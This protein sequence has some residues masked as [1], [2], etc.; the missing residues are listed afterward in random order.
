MMSSSIYIATTKR[1][2]AS[3]RSKT[4]GH[5][6]VPQHEST[7]QLLASRRES[8][9]LRRALISRSR[10]L[11]TLII[12]PRTPASRTKLVIIFTKARAEGRQRRYKGRKAQAI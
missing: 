3:I 1:K 4:S 7:L 8:L 9:A 11:L 2:V 12:R 10:A 6:I 5:Y